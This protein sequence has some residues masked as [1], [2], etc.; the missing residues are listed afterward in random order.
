[1]A[2]LQPVIDLVELCALHGVRHVVI[3]PGSRS[4]ALTLAFARN[5]RIHT[6]VCM[7][8]RAAGFMA[9]GI[10]QQ[11]GAPAA[12]VCTSGTAAYNLAPAVAEAFFQQVPLLVLTADRPEEWI[13]QHDGQ[14]IF[15][16]EIYGRH[17]KKSLALPSGY[18]H[19]D[20]C[21]QVNRDINE[22]ML[23]TVASPPGPVHVNVP[24][25]EPFYPL[26]DEIFEPSGHIRKVSRPRMQPSMDEAEWPPIREAWDRSGRILLASG[27]RTPDLHLNALLERLTARE[28]VPLLGDVT[29]NNGSGDRH[30]TAHDLFLK[31]KPDLRPEL[32]VTFGKSFVS[33]QLKNF[34]RAFPAAAHWHIGEDPHLIDTFQSLTC[35][36]PV[37]PAYFFEKLREPAQTGPVG[38]VKAARTA[39]MARWTQE[40]QCSRALLSGFIGRHTELSDLTALEAVIRALPAGAQLHLGN[41][42]PVR[43]ANLLGHGGSGAVFANRGTSGIDGSVSTAVGAALVSGEETWLVVGDVSFLYDRNALLTRPLPA[44][45]KIVVINNGGGNIFRLIDGPARQPELETFFETRHGYTA[46]RTAEDSSLDYFVI[47]DHQQVAGTLA[48]FSAAGSAAL[49]E[50]FTD[51]VRNAALYRELQAATAQ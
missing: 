1:M 19:P 18:S 32:L 37:D 9:L 34:L 51:P 49:L 12:V 10:A 43:Y 50:I 6:H 26:E 39:F 14:T 33:K 7:D 30:I 21:W 11:L 15:Q 5:P 13:H 27:Q 28:Q 8:E 36:F 23:T 3:S 4:A 45:L 31:G 47:R 20:E 16:R 29:A 41:S 24:V 17:V 44:R 35:H 48:A 2:V 25:R 46:R 22:A 42:M 40:E 38:E